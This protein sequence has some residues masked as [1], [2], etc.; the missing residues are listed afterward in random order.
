MD[1]V[2][3]RDPMDVDTI[4]PVAVPKRVGKLKVEY[5]QILAA[6]EE[7]SLDQQ[8]QLLKMLLSDPLLQNL[9]VEGLC[10]DYVDSLIRIETGQSFP[11]QLVRFSGDRI[12]TQSTEKEILFS[13]A[14][15]RLRRL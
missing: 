4:E 14:L 11:V 12:S 9:S 7:F 1:D 3:T 5:E 6:T 13:F 15:N 8:Q 10:S 2:Q